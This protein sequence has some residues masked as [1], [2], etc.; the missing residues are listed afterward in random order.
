[1][2]YAMLREYDESQVEVHGLD[3]SE[4]LIEHTREKLYMAGIPLRRINLTMSEFQDYHPHFLFD[5]IFAGEILEHQQEIRPFL[6]KLFSLL[7]PE[8]IVV[9]TV[10]SGPWESLSFGQTFT[11]DGREIRFH[12]SHFEL[13]DLMDLFGQKGHSLSISPKDYALLGNWIV[14]VANDGKPLGDIDYARKFFTTRPYQSL[15]AVAIVKDEEAHILKMLSSIDKHV[16]EIIVYDTG[17]KD[18]TK[19]LAKQNPKVYLVE[20][21][22][23]DDFSQARNDARKY[24]TVNTDWIL[25]IDADETLIGGAHLRKYL[26]TDLYQGYVLAQHHFSLD[27][28]QDPDVPVRLFR[29]DPAFTWYGSIHEN[30]GISLNEPL[31]PLLRLPNVMLAHTGYLTEGDRRHK[32]Q[33]RNLPLLYQDMQKNPGRLLTHSLLCRD[34]LH[35]IL[36]TQE[37]RQSLALDG[38]MIQQL[39]EVLKVYEPLSDPHSPYHALGWPFYQEALKM[40]GTRGIPTA[41]GH[42]PF[43]VQMIL[44]TDPEP[45]SSVDIWFQTR[46]ELQDFLAIRAEKLMIPHEVVR[47]HPG[48]V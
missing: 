29:N 26:N 1:M 31:H 34:L 47:Y 27:A 43:K 14:C 16:D 48:E 37:A 23:P 35:F 11:P 25:S 45:R 30:I 24:V 33:Q 9:F 12:M 20:G 28:N 15:A 7:T 10:P 44:N 5:M 18:R 17:S 32:V 19:E 39:Y 21:T 13:A 46:Q 42:I 4:R 22:W 2:L 40:L 8:G 38:K 41:Q 6:D 3:F 36:W